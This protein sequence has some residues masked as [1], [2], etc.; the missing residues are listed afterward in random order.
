MV[1]V[2]RIRIEVLNYRRDKMI[3]H[4]FSDMDGTLLNSEGYVTKS[5]VSAIRNSGIPFT[6]VSARA[7]MEMADAIRKLELVDPQIGFNGGLIYQK[8]DSGF[9]VLKDNA[10]NKSSFWKLIK[11]IQN[12]FPMVSCSCYGLNDWYT[13]KI[14][15]GIECES[16]LTG[17]SAKLVNFHEL[18]NVKLYKIMMITFDLE[19]MD[20]LNEEL[21]NMNISD[22]SIKRSGDNYLEITSSLAQ[23]SKGIDYIQKL[24]KLSKEEMAAFGDGH[25]DLPMLTNV[26]VPIVMGNASPEI[27]EYGKYITKNNDNDGVAYGIKNFLEV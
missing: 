17:Q 26:G 19:L 11:I 15:D 13:E 8:I 2:P 6:L 10:L 25:N 5:N 3:K 23:K 20:K 9:K 24:E 16:N 1:P 18:T 22:V 12:H 21:L 27:K 4:I 14:D 7:P